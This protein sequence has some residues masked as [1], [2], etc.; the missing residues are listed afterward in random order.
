[1]P[2]LIRTL[3][4]VL[5]LAPL[6]CGGGPFGLLPGSGLEGEVR[7]LPADWDFAGS[8]GTAQLETKPDEPYSVNLAYT[9]LDGVLYINA[10]DTETQWVQNMDVNPNVRLRIDGVIYEL[11]AERVTDAE[12]IA[13][14]GKAWTS[15]SRF[16]RDPAE[17]EEAWVYRLGAR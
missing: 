7:Q 9:I 11:R 1:M 5:V 14:F 4:M 8:S 17:L 13:R 16:M 10:G 2:L 6:G 3:A 15:G 12:E